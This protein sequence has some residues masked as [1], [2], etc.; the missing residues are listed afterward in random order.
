M[1]RL[2][3]TRRL[4]WGNSCPNNDPYSEDL[5]LYH[6]FVDHGRLCPIDGNQGMFSVIS[7]GTVLAGCCLLAAGCGRGDDAVGLKGSVTYNGAPV[8]SG[9]ITFTPTSGGTTFGAQVVNGSYTAEKAASGNY[10]ALVRADRANTGPM[11]RE[12]AAQQASAPP[13]NYIPE[14]ADGN[15]QTVEVP[16]GGG[17]IDFKITGPPRP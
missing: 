11:T 14:T 12:Q 10:T 8:E 3:M 1:P 6:Q 7:K 16:S 4:I 17:T 5:R 9:T 2:R 13:P 15:S